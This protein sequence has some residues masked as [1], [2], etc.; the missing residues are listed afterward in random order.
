MIRSGFH[1][2]EKKIN[3]GCNKELHLSEGQRV[4]QNPLVYVSLT[5]TLAPSHL[6]LPDILGKQILSA[7]QTAQT[8]L[9]YAS[10]EESIMDIG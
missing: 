9:M 6:E 7:D 1:I 8:K 10:Q 4:S 2:K 5:R 3:P